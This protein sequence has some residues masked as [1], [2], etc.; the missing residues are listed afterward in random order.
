[1]NAHLA[2]DVRA[3]RSRAPAPARPR[4]RVVHVTTVPETLAFLAGQA[5]AWTARGIE[6]HAVSAPGPALEAFGRREGVRVHSVPMSRR[7]APAEDLRALAALTRLFRDLRPDVVHGHTPK[8]GLLAMAAAAAAGVR[9]RLY[10]LHGL[11]LETAA[12]IRR[13]ILRTT[14]RIAGALAR[15][16][17]AV[18][19]SLRRRALKEGLVRPEKLRVLGAGTVNGVDTD[20]FAPAPEE[21]KAFRRAWGIPESAR[22]VG[23]VGRVVR[24]KGVG[25]LVSAWRR[26]REEFPDLHLLVVG[27]MEPQDPI[28]EEAR[29]ALG[30]DR[31]V[32]LTGALDRT[33]P[34]YAAMDVV[35]L[36]TYR[37][38]FP[39]VP[40]EAA[41]MGLPVVTTRVTGAVDAVMEGVTGT[42]VPPRN[43]EA[44]AA[45]IRRYLAD[46]ALRRRH[47]EAGRR[48]ARRDF[49]PAR[50]QEETAA[51]YF[52][53]A[54]RRVRTP[55]R[56]PA[57]GRPLER[58]VKRIMDVAGAV[59]GLVALSPVLA[60]AAAAV[61]W[62]M[63]PP[64]LFRQVRP[65]RRGRPFTLYK[66]RTMRPGKGP[67]A[68]RVTPLGR[69]L[70]ALSL[71][72]LPQ[73]WNVLRGDMSLVGPRPLLMEYLG[74]YSPEQARRHDVP[75][76]LTGWTQ[77][78][79]RNGIS[80]DEKFAL[81]LWYVD[82]WSLALDLRILARTFGRVFAR[83]G[84]DG[85]GNR[86]YPDFMNEAPS[87]EGDGR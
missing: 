10:T 31:R 85:P 63:G 5:A 65:G 68:E 80:W 3:A 76:G 17:H 74:R 13:A 29:K 72:E 40:L 64:I 46:E 39:Q 11:P 51:E 22:V 34:A 7:I 15:R 32:R 38:G 28:P 70:R 20:V 54:G 25:D 49:R 82:H 37:E 66:F 23:F 27:P 73:L 35:V 44:L 2:I 36:P 57:R 58:L 33:R 56:R 9:G 6:M 1:M 59:G 18:S 69:L 71:D 30:S 47:G 21:G 87:A 14:E 61:R 86:T 42:L 77:V 48:R 60:L 75:P 24:D 26:L 53:L 62:T 55:D 19:F 12:G 67:D 79:G 41:A 4:L 43:P 50:L 84:V 16:V 52:D 78:N 45:A 8:G 83:S 81:D